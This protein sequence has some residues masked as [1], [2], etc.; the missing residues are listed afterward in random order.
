MQCRIALHCAQRGDNTAARKAQHG[1]A[2]PCCQS[3]DAGSQHIKQ[4]VRRPR[5]GANLRND[6]IK[7]RIACFEEYDNSLE[8]KEDAEKKKEELAEAI[9][10][11]T[12]KMEA[13]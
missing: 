11:L 6:I 13:M 10:E 9:G 3:R 12:R 1:H 2:P 5:L 7:R 4:C 8:R